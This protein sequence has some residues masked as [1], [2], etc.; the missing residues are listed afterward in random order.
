MISAARL[1]IDEAASRLGAAEDRLPART[2]PA[3][4]IPMQISLAR[5]TA[6]MN[7]SGSPPPVAPSVVGG[8]DR[9][10]IAGESRRVGGEVAERS[11]GESADRRPRGQG[12]RERRSDPG[13]KHA[14]STT[15]IVAPTTV[16]IIRNQPLRS[17][18]PSCGWHTIA[19]DVPAQKGLSSSSQNAT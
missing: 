4:A 3:H 8:D 13:G 11:G 9:R 1:A 19:A 2:A 15:I 18:A 12:A 10:R 6:N 16:P 7:T 14:V 17:A 5:V